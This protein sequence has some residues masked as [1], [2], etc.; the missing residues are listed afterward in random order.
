MTRTAARL[1]DPDVRLLAALADPVRLEII[2]ELAGSSE[3]CACDLTSCCDVRQP[4]VSHHLRVLREAGV[5]VSDRR[6][7]NIYYRVAPNLIER[8]GTIARGLVPGGL[9]P[10]DVLTAPR[11]GPELTSPAGPLG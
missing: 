8:L 11:R 7:S 10:T 2:R 3:V 9:I 6:G 1:V 5:V 4:T